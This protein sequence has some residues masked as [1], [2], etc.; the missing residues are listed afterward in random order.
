MQEEGNSRRSK[1][2][3]QKYIFSYMAQDRPDIVV[4]ATSLPQRRVAPPEGTKGHLELGI[5]H[6]HGV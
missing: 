6:P 1:G 4:M 2:H 5:T 3:A